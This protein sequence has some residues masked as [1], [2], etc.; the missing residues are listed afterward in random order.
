MTPR[1]HQP[2]E[3]LEA[4]ETKLLLEGIFG[5]YGY[6]F[7]DYASSSVRRRIRAAVELED[8]SSISALHARI[9]HE[10]DCMERFLRAVSVHV[11]S[12]FRD[13]GF[14]IAFRRHVVPL[15]GTY[16]FIR[17]WIAGCSTGE[18]VYSLAILLQEEGLNDRCRIYAT[19][20]SDIVLNHAAEGIFP[21]PKMKEFTSNYQQAGGQG[22]FSAYYTAK[23]DN[24]VMRASLK[25]NLVFSQHNLVSDSGFNEFHVILCR[26]VMIYFNKDLQ[27]RVLQTIHDSL[28]TLGV[29]GLG[30]RESLRYSPLET[31]YE[32]IDPS[33]RLY[34]R[35]Q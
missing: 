16:P 18:E 11:T 27:K 30:Q 14:Y 12:M 7:R 6:D 9:L 2:D 3:A 25:K 28:V 8:L 33:A 29:V 24:A 35:V 23:Y 26:N 31:C 32:E 5:R 22:D 15:L 10:P 4:L 1:P 21:L 19:D 34:R 20:L 13:P 17:V